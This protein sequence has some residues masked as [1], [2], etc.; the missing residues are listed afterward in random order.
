M[1]SRSKNNAKKPEVQKPEAP[2]A[3]AVP[4]QMSAPRPKTY[5]WAG[6]AGLALLSAGVVYTVANVVEPRSKTATQIDFATPGGEVRSIV[7]R[8]EIA[9]KANPVVIDEAV[10][11]PAEKAPAEVSIVGN[12]VNV[13]EAAPAATAGVEQLTQVIRQLTALEERILELDGQLAEN[14]ARQQAAPDLTRV[15]EQLV[16]TRVG[17]ALS[18]GADMALALAE[19]RSVFTAPEAH[20]LLS[21]LDVMTAEGVITPLSLYRSAT[22]AQ[23]LMPPRADE[24]L[25]EAE[26]LSFWQRLR[27]RLS[28]WIDVRPVSEGAQA[29]TADLEQLV[30][31]LAVNDVQT[32]ENLL[33][34]VHL[35][36]DTRLDGLRQTVQRYQTQ[37]RLVWQLQMGS[38]QPVAEVN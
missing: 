37:R 32:A 18:G 26:N 9:R 30:S 5:L 31:A 17:L 33:Q 24:V 16:A 1:A 10:D 8:T 38:Q 3:E 12:T 23:K 25:A 14:R 21:Q 13:N 4:P 11:T 28:R 7:S 6:V 35:S 27:M 34:G 15:R 20:A 29:W 19:A 2:Q 36:A 22:A